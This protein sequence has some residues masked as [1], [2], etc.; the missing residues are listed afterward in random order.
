MGARVLWA[1][2]VGFLTGVFM[3]SF[4]PLSW[5]FAALCFL[6]AAVAVWSAYTQR[7][8][9]L[10]VCAV[11]CAAF[12][13]G[14]LRMDTAVLTGDPVLSGRLGAMVEVEGFVID[15]PDVRDSNVHLTID[16]HT[17]R[18]GSTTI[19]VAARLLAFVSLHTPV[20]YGDG[21][22]AKGTLRLPE[23]FESGEGRVFGYPSYLG[24]DGIAYQLA[25]AQAQRTGEHRSN[26]AKRIAF[27]VKHALL[28][29]L[30]RALPEPEAG[31][32]SGITLGDKRS[33]GG[34]L[35]EVFQRASLIHIV[36]LSGYNITVVINAAVRTLEWLPRTVRFGMSGLVVVFFI[37]MTGGAATAVRAGLM[38]SLAVYARLTGRT[39]LALRALGVAA[40]IMIMWNPWTLAFDPSFQLSALATLGLITLTPFFE[41]YAM[42]VPERFA[43]REIVC[44]TLATQVT[45]LPLL[46]Y[47]SGTL[48]FVALPANTLALVAVPIAMGFSTFAAIM[49]VWTGP[50]APLF[51][52]PA[53][54][55]LAYI[56]GVGQFFAA[57]PF[58][59]VIV[60]AFSAWIVVAVYVALFIGLVYR[61]HM[62]QSRPETGI[63][64]A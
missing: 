5:P 45:V 59:S 58:S 21:V 2:V 54:A 55:L 28:A 23:A 49:G 39:F 48:S 29:G 61:R 57:L 64:G 15:E 32:A 3:R 34:E 47:Q 33:I 27:G 63:V 9:T 4:L 1:I 36:V 24:K 22:R 60:P 20:A 37:L 8:R 17:L 14:I 7:T 13:T 26:P 10:V 46:L 56:I 53:Y 6:L 25:F 31:L 62:K 19:P 38:A 30:Q 40:L 35:S 42:W 41:R 18:V 50:L 16:A 11:V 51:G 52:F 12:G 43:L 44:S